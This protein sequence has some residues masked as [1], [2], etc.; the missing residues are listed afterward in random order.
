MVGA[1]RTAFGEDALPELLV[2]VRESNQKQIKHERLPNEARPA[3]L[4]V[5]ALIA[6]PVDVGIRC[7][8]S[9]AVVR[10]FCNCSKQRTQWDLSEDALCILLVD[11][12][13]SVA[14]VT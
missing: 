8:V 9:K 10:D 6:L 11:V 1:H 13:R 14:A 2:D 3:N 12:W 5:N 7:S 4:G